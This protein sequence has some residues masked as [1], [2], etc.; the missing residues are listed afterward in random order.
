MADGAVVEF[1]V[2]RGPL[3]LA[4]HARLSDVEADR[5]FVD[6]QIKGPFGS[7]ATEHAFVPADSA[8]AP[9][10][11]R[12]SATRS[13]SRCRSGHSA[14]SGHRWSP[15]TCG[16]LFAWRYHTTRADLELHR[17]LALPRLR[18][19]V[20]G[21]SGFLGSA[22]V[23]SLRPGGHEVVRIVRSTAKVVA[24]TTTLD[25]ADS[26]ALLE[27][28]DAVVHLAG[29]GIADGRCSAARRHE[30]LSSRVDGT[31]ALVERLARLKHRPRV[32][33]VASAVGIYGPDAGDS[34]HHEGSPAGK[35]FLAD[36]AWEGA[37]APVADWARLVHLRFGVVLDPRGGALAKMLLPF[38]L[39]A[40]GPIGG[41]RQFCRGL[42]A[43]TPPPRC[44]G[45]SAGRASVDPS[46]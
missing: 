37:A 7:R 26:S 30:I 21:A 12:R 9:T 14:R 33:A 20:S 17:R 4:W 45:R 44:C 38:R 1:A 31:R 10:R 13:T 28:L 34:A 22:L 11:A 19:A 8:F 27:G 18:V 2:R 23:E 36:R 25:A 32:V 29:A 3:A 16:R 6:T 46:T 42:A 24:N 41:G 5:G 43:T 35:G 40:G 15:A 39:G